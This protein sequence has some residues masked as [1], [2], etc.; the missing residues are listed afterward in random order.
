VNGVILPEGL[1]FPIDL[2][3][4]ATVDVRIHP[5]AHSLIAQRAALFALA[6][7]GEN[8]QNY[9]GLVTS[10]TAGEQNL[11]AILSGA[12]FE[13]LNTENKQPG[14]VTQQPQSQQ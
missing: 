9:S 11:I 13:P 2:A 3:G 10:L 8:I 5:V 4:S 14:I 6:E 1:I 12:S 7:D